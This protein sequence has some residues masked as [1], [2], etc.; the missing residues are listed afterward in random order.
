MRATPTLVFRH[1]EFISPGLSVSSFRNLS[2]AVDSLALFSLI[3]LLTS[4]RGVFM[5]D[6]RISNL[7]GRV[8]ATIEQLSSMS[9]DN[10]QAWLDRTEAEIDALRFEIEHNQNV[11]LASRDE[12][13]E[14]LEAIRKKALRV[15]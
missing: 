9:E 14:K 4:N 3:N 7:D 11:E 1:A 13:I 2:G 8:G 15:I 12:L 10:R 5:Y 6:A